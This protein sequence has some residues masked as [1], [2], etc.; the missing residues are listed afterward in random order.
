MDDI[1][2]SAAENFLKHVEII[3]LVVT[4]NISRKFPKRIISESDW[5]V[6][7]NRRIAKIS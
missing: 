7:Q 1:G 5:N 4:F 3:E 6:W 2:G